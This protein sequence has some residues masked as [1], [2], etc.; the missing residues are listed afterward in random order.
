MPDGSKGEICKGVNNNADFGKHFTQG[1]NPTVIEQI[2]EPPDCFPVMKLEAK[3]I[4]FTDRGLTL[5]EEF[6]VGLTSYRSATY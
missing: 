4:G 3:L 1:S 5:G 6:Q 2:L